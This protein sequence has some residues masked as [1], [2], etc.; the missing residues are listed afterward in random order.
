MKEYTNIE[1][2]KILEKTKATDK[3]ASSLA[4]IILADE[5]KQIYDFYVNMDN[6]HLQLELKPSS[7][8]NEGGRSNAKT[9]EN[10]ASRLSQ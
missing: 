10:G 4:S 6:I 9:T 5:E 7:L 8:G 3:Q 2:F 1:C